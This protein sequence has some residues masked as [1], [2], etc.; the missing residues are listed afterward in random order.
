MDLVG[1]SHFISRFETFR[2]G[3]VPHSF[4]LSGSDDNVSFDEHADARKCDRTEP[5]Q[6]GLR[7]SRFESA[8]KLIQVIIVDW[9]LQT[10]GEEDGVDFRTN[11][12]VRRAKCEMQ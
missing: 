3:G 4:D 9:Q 6:F 2:I 7:T 10:F 5:R 12:T 11:I 8:G 1:T